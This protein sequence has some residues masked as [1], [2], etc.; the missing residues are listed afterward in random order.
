MKLFRWGTK[1]LFQIG[2][3]FFKKTCSESY[4]KSNNSKK[5]IV[6]KVE[7]K[8]P[9]CTNL[10]KGYFVQIG[11]SKKPSDSYI[12]KFYIKRNKR[13]FTTIKF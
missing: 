10:S 9:S 12:T 11:L 2:W 13:N 4:W 5:R 1:V 3:N 7:E 8:K 6:E